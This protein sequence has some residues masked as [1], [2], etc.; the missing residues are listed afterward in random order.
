MKR[1]CR[2][3]DDYVRTILRNAARAAR[4]HLP[5]GWGV[6]MF[7][8]PQ[9]AP[10]DSTTVHYISTCNRADMIDAVQAWLNRQRH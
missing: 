6:T 7:V 9:D 10:S 5:D 2:R 1:D 8:F 3:E 4:G